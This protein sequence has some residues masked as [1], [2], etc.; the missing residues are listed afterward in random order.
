[1]LEVEEEEDDDGDDDDDDDDGDEVGVPDDWWDSTRAGTANVKQTR[2]G[3]RTV[4]PSMM[5]KMKDRSPAAGVVDAPA[6]GPPPQARKECKRKANAIYPLALANA[7]SV[8][9]LKKPCCFMSPSHACRR[10]RMGCLWTRPRRDG[11]RDGN[12]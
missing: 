12:T 6:G 2:H 11:R 10:C 7:A 5:A 3:R 1:M 8:A 9:K 4:A